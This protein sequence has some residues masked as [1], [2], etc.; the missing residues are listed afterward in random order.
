M[1]DV[2]TRAGEDTQ[3]PPAI[4]EQHLEEYTQIC[5]SYRAGLKSILDITRYYMLWHAGLAAAVSYVL[6]SPKLT[7]FVLS[8]CGIKVKIL[9]VFISVL[10]ILSGFGA[11]GISRRYEELHNSIKPRA[12]QLESLYDMHFLTDFE[13]ARANP[14]SLG[15]QRIA[16][17][18]F[19]LLAAMWLMFLVYSFIP[20]RD[21]LPR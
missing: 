17:V 1:I 21:S 11:I 14:R 7:D 19:L 16:L 8:I 13:K 2:P 18:L 3:P 10:G 12:L 20:D 9:V 15:G 6:S 5:E 4:T